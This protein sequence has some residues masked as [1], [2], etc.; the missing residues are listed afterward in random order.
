VGSIAAGGRY[1]DLIAKFGTK[2][3]ADVAAIGVSLGIER[4]FTILEQKHKD[5]KQ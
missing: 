4:I 1:D 5:D 3:V 2:R